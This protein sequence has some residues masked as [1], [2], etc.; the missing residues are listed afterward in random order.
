MRSTRTTNKTR[1][2][3]L[4]AAALAVPL[5]MG[6]GQG[7]QASQAQDP[8][9]GQTSSTGQ[10]R[11]A[12]TA[13]QVT[14]QGAA[15]TS[16]TGS[17]DHQGTA[18]DDTHAARTLPEVTDPSA[19]TGEETGR[20]PVNH[21]LFGPLEVV[22]YFH[23]TSPEGAAP[24]QGRPSYAIYQNGRAVGYMSSPE[25]TKEVSF[26]PQKSLGGQVWDVATEHPVDKYGNVYLSY[27]GGV[28]VLTPTAKGLDSHG[29]MPGAEN[30]E[31]PFQHAGLRL[32]AAGEPMVIQRYVDQSGNETGGEA[33]WAWQDGRFVAL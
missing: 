18:T 25:G 23:V 29:T 30:P 32:D 31:Y 4:A 2:T 3:A 15:V 1:T 13:D 27:D 6:C 20:V 19:G 8:A 11:S 16:G 21:P 28:T 26:A 24:F 22:T 33:L 5:L 14:G 17:A 7:V 10:S 12:T 9:A